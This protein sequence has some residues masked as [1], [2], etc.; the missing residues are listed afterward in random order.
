MARNWGMFVSFEG[1]DGVG[2][3]TLVKRLCH[4]LVEDGHKFIA[5]REPGGSPISEQIRKLAKDPDFSHMDYRTEALLMVA[6]R[7]QLVHKTYRPALAEGAVV[8]ADRYIDSTY[9]YQVF[10]R[11]LDMESIKALNTFATEGLL[12]DRT[13]LLQA[14][15]G[16]ITK[17]LQAD[18]R[19]GDRLD[20]QD[21]DF[22]RRVQQG[23]LQLAQ[24][25]PQRF[26]IID[27][28]QTPQHMFEA[29]Y[30]D[31]QQQQTS[32]TI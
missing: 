21:K 19:H 15:L 3:T 20:N 13:Y 11:G 17:R 6:A 8:V 25:E 26:V 31:F 29:V 27:A 5:T 23:Y 7:A 28:S 2:K 12:P 4:Q 1:I 10:G 14:P 22:F 32:L 24:A 30:A 9:A 16:M 18:K